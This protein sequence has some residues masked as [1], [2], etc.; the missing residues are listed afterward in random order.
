[1]SNQKFGDTKG[2][3]RSLKILKGESKFEDTKGAIRSL[4]ILK[5]QSEV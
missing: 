3:I 4:K 2:A 1:M 5:G